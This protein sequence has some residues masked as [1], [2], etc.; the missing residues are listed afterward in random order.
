MSVP[1][2]RLD[3]IASIGSL[4]FAVQESVLLLVQVAPS[5]LLSYN[6]LCIEL[7]ADEFEEKADCR[8]VIEPL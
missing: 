4:S 3:S 8:L 2:S 7:A 6:Q 5:C 1:V